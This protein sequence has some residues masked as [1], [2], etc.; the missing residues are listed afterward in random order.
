MK[1]NTW[2]LQKTV[3]PCSCSRTLPHSVPEAQVPPGLASDRFAGQQVTPQE[4]WQ[5]PVWFRG[6]L[7]EQCPRSC[8]QSS[9]GSDSA[10]YNQ[11]AILS[12]KDSIELPISAVGLL[13][14]YLMLS[15]QA[16]GL[17]ASKLPAG[18][19]CSFALVLVS[20]FDVAYLLVVLL[21]FCRW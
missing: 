15:E 12:L 20:Q 10:L 3:P 17:A 8:L 6:H 1:H 16:G 4:G 7:A 9:L 21:S 18:F 13:Q 11:L 19:G 14:C 2:D 5:P